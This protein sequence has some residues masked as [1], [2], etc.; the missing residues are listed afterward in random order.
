[1]HDAPTIPSGGTGAAIPPEASALFASLAEHLYRGDAEGDVYAAVTAA[2]VRLVAGCDRSCIM[3]VEKGGLRTVGATDEV[4]WQIDQLEKLAD[5]GPCVDAID[6]EAVQ[7]D[8]DIRVATPWPKLAAMVLEQTPVKGM[9]GFRLLVDGRKAGALNLF[10]DTAGA[11]DDTSADQGAVIAAFASV[12]LMTLSARREARELR[13]GLAS[14]RE[15]GKAVGLLMAAHKVTAEEAFA[16]LR[17]TSQ[18]LNLKLA[19]VAGL[20]VSGRE[21]QLR[22]RGRGQ[23]ASDAGVDHAAEGVDGADPVER[24]SAD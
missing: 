11:F 9:L 2:A 22:P 16:L 23:V 12:A 1:M 17:K 18:D 6:E 5:E 10:S 13:E 19:A 24:L 8:P 3:L 21:D 4:A 15:I 7:I 14:N 20:V